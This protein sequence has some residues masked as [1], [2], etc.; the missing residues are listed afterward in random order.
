MTEE[1]QRDP[2]RAVEAMRKHIA[3]SRL[4]LQSSSQLSPSHTSG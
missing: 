3:E 2:D 1:A 4:V